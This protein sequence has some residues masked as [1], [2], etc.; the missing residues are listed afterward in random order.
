ML[1]STPARQ[2]VEQGAAATV[3]TRH[4]MLGFHPVQRL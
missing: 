1:S 4:C 2:H 3:S